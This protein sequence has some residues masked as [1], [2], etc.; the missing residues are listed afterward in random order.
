MAKAKAT[1]SIMA[2]ALHRQNDTGPCNCPH[3]GSYSSV[4]GSE[5]VFCNGLPVTRVG[6]P[7]SCMLCSQPGIHITGSPN[8]FS[9]GEDYEF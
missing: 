4:N 3:G 9:G 1:A 7:T 2:K 6:D 5:S 8:V